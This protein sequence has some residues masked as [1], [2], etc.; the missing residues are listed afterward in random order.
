M[1]HS[2]TGVSTKLQIEMENMATKNRYVFPCK[3]WLATDEDDG[4]ILREMAAEGEDIR[5]PES[6]ESTTV[7]I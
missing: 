2:T 4:S 3:R 5:K 1:L 7:A 6:C